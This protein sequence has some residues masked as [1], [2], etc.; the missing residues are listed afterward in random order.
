[1]S[2]LQRF[3]LVISLAFIAVAALGFAASG[4]SME[5]DMNHAARILTI[6]PVNFHHN[7]VHGLFGVWGLLSTRRWG[8]SRLF[9][10]ASG[11]LY[12]ALVPIGILSPTL[13]GL[14][15]IGGSDVILHATIGAILALAGFMADTAPVKAEAAVT[16]PLA[17]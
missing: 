11:V 6:F 3:V 5:A 16:E 4:F 8:A 10:R 9:A 7:M 1:M 17:A 14:M 15:P 12:L 2:I 13:G